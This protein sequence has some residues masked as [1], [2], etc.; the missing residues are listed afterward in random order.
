MTTLQ[1]FVS[2]MSPLRVMIA[3]VI[4]WFREIAAANLTFTHRY[5]ALAHLQ[6]HLFSREQQ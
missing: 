4:Y 1:A 5:L 6:T 2:L 3:V